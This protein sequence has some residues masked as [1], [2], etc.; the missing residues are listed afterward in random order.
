MQP[1]LQ[2]LFGRPYLYLDRCETTQR[3]LDAAQPEGAVALCEEQTAGRGRLGRRWEA[4]A[5]TSIL[6][7]VVLRPPRER[8]PAELTLVGG[9]A[10]AIAIERA[11]GLAAQLKWPNDVMLDRRK[12][13]GGLAELKDGAVVLGIGVNVNQRPGD[14]PDGTKAPAGSLR[15]VTGREHDRAALLV[16]LLLELERRYEA[17]REGGLDAVYD[18]LG[19][20]D[21]LRGRRVTVDGVEGTAQRIT[22]EGLL[23][24]ETEAEPLLVGSGEVDYRG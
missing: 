23:L 14:L 8:K 18:D 17:W 13:A 4:P 7:S 9:L 3:M 19:A 1:L 12:V 15:S 24:V 22:R 11:T 5:G 20:R 21:F 16:D 10:A 6:V 2:G